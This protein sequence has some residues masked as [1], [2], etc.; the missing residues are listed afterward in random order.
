MWESSNRRVQKADVNLESLSEIMTS[1]WGNSA[2]ARRPA[3]VS[4]NS[5]L[6]NVGHIFR[7]CFFASWNS[8]RRRS[9][10]KN[11][12]LE[13][14]TSVGTRGAVPGGPFHRASTGRERIKAIQPEG[15]VLFDLTI[16]KC[17]R[18]IHSLPFLP[19]E[20]D[21]VASIPRFHS[22]ITILFPELS[23]R[24]RSRNAFPQHQREVSVLH[25]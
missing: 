13:E 21:E 14:G 20:Q 9:S 2:K 8:I 4:L 19:R 3:I 23:R 7:E 22:I 12:E 25:N 16:V 6:E 15:M 11:L 17:P 18:R 10:F 5:C 24:R 1:G